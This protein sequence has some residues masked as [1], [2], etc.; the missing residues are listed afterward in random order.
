[1]DSFLDTCN[2]YYYVYPI[3]NSFPRS[4]C[5]FLSFPEYY[6]L[7]I[8]TEKCYLWSRAKQILHS[9]MFSLESGCVCPHSLR[10]KSP[11]Q[12]NKENWNCLFGEAQIT[13]GRCY[14]IMKSKP[15]HIVYPWQVAVW[16]FLQLTSPL[17]SPCKPGLEVGDPMGGCDSEW[18]KHLGV[19]VLGFSPQS[20]TFQ[21]WPWLVC[22]SSQSLCCG[23][24]CRMQW[25]WPQG[26]VT[27][28][29]GEGMWSAFETVQSVQ[30]TM[31]SEV[32]AT[33]LISLFTQTSNNNPQ[34]E[35]LKF[36]IQVQ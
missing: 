26:I 19:R 21:L 35:I 34:M 15:R 5:K 12:A 31:L 25:L 32:I 9:V 14:Y 17:M 6:S 36:S 8:T 22:F 11:A 18:L 13:K 4:Q 20:A 30:Q 23:L 29:Q 7:E 1:M 2:F 28:M 3:Q 33:E 27:K 10:L 16:G 24:I